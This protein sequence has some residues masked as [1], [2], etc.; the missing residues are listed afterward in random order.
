MKK[1]L[2][3]VMNKIALG[4]ISILLG[5]LGI[6][7]FILG[8]W[9]RGLLYL[10]ITILLCWTVLAPVVIQVLALV[11]GIVLLS[12]SDEKFETVKQNKGKGL[13]D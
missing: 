7:W 1:I 6:H 8:N 2:K 4:V 12:M 5:T 9:M 3:I 11:E 13:F 10:L